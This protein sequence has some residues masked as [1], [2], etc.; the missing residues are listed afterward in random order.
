MHKHISDLQR[1]FKPADPAEGE[2]AMCT[3]L[4]P[5]NR[6]PADLTNLQAEKALASFR[7]AG[8]H[9]L[10]ELGTAFLTEYEE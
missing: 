7:F 9:E 4:Q 3:N 6:C 2:K 5:S 8:L 1:R 10:H